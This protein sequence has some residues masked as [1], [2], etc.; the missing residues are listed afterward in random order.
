MSVLHCSNSS[1]TAFEKAKSSGYLL[2]EGTL[3]P[4]V[5]LD[6]RL[7]CRIENKVPMT[8]IHTYIDD[9]YIW[10]DDKTF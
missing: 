1:D 4:Y 3:H 8:V 7:C 9:T 2:L 6:K 5:K 10:G